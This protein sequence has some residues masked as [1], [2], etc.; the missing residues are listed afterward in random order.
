MKPIF[1]YAL[2]NLDELRDV[3]QVEEQ[4]QETQQEAE[5]VAEVV[6]PDN[7]SAIALAEKSAEVIDQAIYLKE[8]LSNGAMEALGLC[9]KRLNKLGVELPVDVSYESQALAPS[10]EVYYQQLS[11]NLH[12]AAERLK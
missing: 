6:I 11:N 5:Q 2:E 12:L 10:R 8:P 7:T 1:K 9:V 4:L 3:E